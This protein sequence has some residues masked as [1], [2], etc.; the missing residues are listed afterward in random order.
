MR[1]DTLFGMPKGDRASIPDEFRRIEAW[2]TVDDSALPP[3]RQK[4]YAR[5]VKAITLYLT[6]PEQS[7]AAISA[8]M[9]IPDER[10]Q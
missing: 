6:A 3:A 4:T 7:V 2:P 5:R 1:E 9:G 8:E 10:D